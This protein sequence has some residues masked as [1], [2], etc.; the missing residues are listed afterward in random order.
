MIRKTS[1]RNVFLAS[2]AASLTHWLLA[3]LSIWL[4]GG[5]DLR[6][7]QPF[8]RS[9]DGL[10]QC[11]LQGLPY[12]RNFLFGTLAYGGLMFGAFEWMKSRNTSLQ[13]I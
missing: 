8:S 12:L 10:L 5:T 2:I 3:D 4:S 11:Y 6:T 1:W 7:M 13:T 9:V